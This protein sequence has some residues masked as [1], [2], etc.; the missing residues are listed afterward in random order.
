[1]EIVYGI[2]VINEE[3]RKLILDKLQELKYIE[4]FNSVNFRNAVWYYIRIHVRTI[5]YS[6]STLLI[7]SGY[8]TK[9]VEIQFAD[10]YSKLLL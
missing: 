1:M 6:N 9:Y 8:T 7:S 5:G 10:L 2:K 4:K 3:R